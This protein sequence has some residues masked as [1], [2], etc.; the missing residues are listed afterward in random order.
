MT[1]STADSGRDVVHRSAWTQAGFAQIP[2]PVLFDPELT[3]GAKMLYALLKWHARGDATDVW[4]GMERLCE[5]LGVGDNACRRYRE[6]LRA[7]GLIS[8]KRR[9]LGRPNLYTLIEPDDY[10]TLTSA[11]GG[12]RS[13]DSEDLDGLE[14]ADE[15]DVVEVEKPSTP[16]VSP[17]SSEVAVAAARAPAKVDGK[18]VVATE[19]D[20]A[21][22]ILE[23]WN[24]QTGQALRAT[25]HLSKIILRCR[26]YPEATLDDHERI[27]R[28]NLA[29]PWWKGPPS[30]SVIYGNDAQFERS[31]ETAR[32]E[33]QK[34]KPRV[35]PGA[36][37]YGRGLTTRQI[38]DDAGVTLSMEEILDGVQP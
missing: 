29:D 35:D 5:T 9:G 3:I 34:T 18:V 33:G 31:I 20:F 32:G 7:A 19:A 22:A 26:E 13:A 27:I 21:R 37:R 8:V 4:P 1:D 12:S 28:A 36:T 15:V 38:L 6:E 14:T 25:T 30:P 23:T 11:D 16:P 17:P 2:A 24:E 10:R